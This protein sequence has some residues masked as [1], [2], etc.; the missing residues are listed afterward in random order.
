MKKAFLLV[1]VLLGAPAVAS[2]QQPQPD[3]DDPTG[4]QPAPGDPNDPI[5]DPAT[6]SDP[7]QPET[8]PDTTTPPPDAPTPTTVPPTPP[9]PQ[10]VVVTP[11]PD[12]PE[13][14]PVVVTPTP[15]RVTPVVEEPTYVDRVGVALTVGAGV[16]SFLDA[17]T[18]DFT[19]PGAGWAARMSIG[20]RELLGLELGYTGTAQEIDALGLDNDAVLVS[21]GVDAALRVNLG[22]EAAMQPFLFGGLGWRHYNVTN[23]DTNTSSIKDEDDV[24][25]FPVGAGLG[26]RAG[27]LALELRTTF[28]PAGDS[29]LMGGRDQINDP[30]DIDPGDLDPDDIDDP[31]DRDSQSTLHNWSATLGAGFEF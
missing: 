25:E 6:P 20:T 23:A 21:N 13:P 1:A 29:D 24:I 12:E 2:A 14:T 26:F 22:P 8:P 15:V 10:P 4:T 17:D 11:P 18:R 19:Q 30:D 27:G 3:P 28:R 31:N 7:A 16:S 5:P 9:A